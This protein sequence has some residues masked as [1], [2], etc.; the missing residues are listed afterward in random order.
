MV[1]LKRSWSLDCCAASRWSTASTNSV[2]SFGSTKRSRSFAKSGCAWYLSCTK[3]N[4]SLAAETQ[5]DGEYD[6]V[7]IGGTLSGCFAALHA[8]EKGLKVLLIE[9]RTFLATEITAPMRPWLMRVGF[10]ALGPKLKDLLLPDQEQDEVGVPFDPTD[11]SGFFGDEIPLFM[12]SVK[13]Q[14]M[15]VLFQHQGLETLS[16]P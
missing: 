14:F 4:A 7:V 16:E 5:V 11:E 13:K 8:A 10:D 9:R 12:G 3:P 2:G 15:E 1:S 6:V